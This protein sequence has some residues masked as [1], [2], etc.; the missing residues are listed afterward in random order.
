ML[1]RHRS[2]LLQSNP[3]S[4]PT[5]RAACN[6]QASFGLWDDPEW[7]D[8]RDRIQATDIA[9]VLQDSGLTLGM[10][11]GNWE[12]R[13]DSWHFRACE[14]GDALLVQPARLVWPCLPPPRRWLW[15]CRQ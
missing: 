3:R 7:A 2:T 5:A 10:Y 12:R 14:T 1:L 9:A 13:G 15:W 8:L 11:Y 6:S 4:Y